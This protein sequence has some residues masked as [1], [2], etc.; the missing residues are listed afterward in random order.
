MI[1]RE[2]WGYMS[3]IHNGSNSE[4]INPL[5]SEVDSTYKHIDDV[6]IKIKDYLSEAINFIIKKSCV[7]EVRLSGLN[8]AIDKA[9][10]LI[11][12]GMTEL[13][14]KKKERLKRLDKPANNE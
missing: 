3:I 7:S 12:P 1:D 10:E 9:L 11:K 13:N 5:T 2:C 4:F 6:V 14:D 8:E